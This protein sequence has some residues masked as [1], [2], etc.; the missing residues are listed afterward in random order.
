MPMTDA[1]KLALASSETICVSVITGSAWTLDGTGHPKR[2]RGATFRRLV[3]DG[4]LARSDTNGQTD[5][6][7]ITDSGKMALD[8]SQSLADAPG[9]GMSP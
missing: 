4:F 8:S 9:P 7:R 1:Q 5:F 6:Y 3:A 2:M